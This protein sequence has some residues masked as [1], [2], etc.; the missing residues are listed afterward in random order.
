MKNQKNYPYNDVEPVSSIKNL[1][2]LAVK[3]AGDKPAFKYKDKD[4]NVI[5][6][7]YREFEEDTRYL[8]TALASFGVVSSHIAVIGK[9][10]YK[11]ILVY[12]TALKSSGV[13]VPVDKELPVGDIINVLDNSDSEVLF[14][15]KQFE[16]IIPQLAEALPKIRY[17]IG[18]D[19]EVTEENRVSF[20]EFYEKGKTLY[21]NGDTSYSSLENDISKLK[22][23]VYTSGTTGMAKGVML[24]E[25][26]LV[27]MVYYGLRISTVY[28]RC[29]S[30]LPYHHTY[31]AV[32]GILVSMHHHACICINEHMK[33][34]LKNLQIYKPDYIFIVPAFAEL[35]YKKIIA[36]AKSTGK[37]KTLMTMIRLSNALRSAGI[38]LRRKMFKSIH[39]V[40]GGNMKK[41]LSGG[42]PLRSELGEFFEAVGLDITNGYGITECSPLIS[43]NRDYFND[44]TTAGVPVECLEVKFEDVTPEGDG[45]ICVKGKT[46][47]MGYYKNEKQTKEVLKDGWFKTGD[48]GRMNEKGQIIITGRKKNIIVLENGKNVYPEEIENYIMSIS[49]VDEV[50]VRGIRGKSGAETG[51]SAE[52]F[53][54]EEEVKKLGDT[55]ILK[56]LKKD[57]ADICVPLPIY[58]H[59][60][61]VR[62]CDKAFEKTT[63]NKIKR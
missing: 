8:G 44:Y 54:N 30:V 24:S 15:S 62:I 20:K 60:S 43:G 2:E 41:I 37:Y 35:F 55:D 7:T 61:E 63:T 25:D 50:V 9:N 34:I 51:L 38:D 28:T 19:R 22:M 29:L 56:K 53:L 48:Y 12:L 42:A 33:A 26:N 1:L 39:A 31:E 52:V 36:N 40:F 11:W 3:E 16:N 27:S 10:S 6:V 17:F 32:A 59:I 49:Y 4:K 23:I 18:F 13:F 58:K 14:Y 21:K 57:I 47:M 46:V 45:E 5:T